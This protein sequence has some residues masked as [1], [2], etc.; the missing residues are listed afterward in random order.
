MDRTLRQWLEG[1]GWTQKQLSIALGVTTRTV[2]R[3]CAAPENVP[4]WVAIALDGL[5]ARMRDPEILGTRA[6]VVVA[7]PP[8]E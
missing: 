6:A 5:D 3:W 8:A 2:E 4:R 7:A 1:Q